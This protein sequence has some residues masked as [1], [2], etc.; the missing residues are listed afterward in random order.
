MRNDIGYL[1]WIN[2]AF[3][4]GCFNGIYKI[5][6]AIFIELAN[7]LFETPYR[8]VPKFTALK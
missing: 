6:Y 2:F 4:K 7:I 5:R 1:F 3:C 8:F